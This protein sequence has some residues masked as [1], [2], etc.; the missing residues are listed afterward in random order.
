MSNKI[1][2]KRGN[3]VPTASNLDR[4]ELGFAESNNGLYTK[5]GEDEIVHLNPI[6]DLK[7]FLLNTV[8][9]VGTVYF[10]NDKTFNP[11]TV[12][13]GTWEN[14]SGSYLYLGEENVGET[15]GDINNPINIQDH[16]LTED[17]L[18]SHTHSLEDIN[19]SNESAGTPSGS[20]NLDSHNHYFNETT[21]G[22]SHGHSAYYRADV[23]SGS[24]KLTVLTTSSASGAAG[25][26][27]NGIDSSSGSHSHSFS[28]YTDSASA[29][30]SFD[31]NQLPFHTHTAS[32]SVNYTGQGTGIE[33][34]VEVNLPRFVTLAWK[35][36]A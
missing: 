27:P 15:L 35:R 26:S 24:A 14:V 4:Y 33:H 13:G 2:V 19:I 25:T 8:Y 12:W 29:S 30:G 1:L 5:N 22:G 16:I 36:T 23:G 3:S 32:G 18:A 17:N 7:T 9:P 20:I 28:G 34:E 10:T 31:G 6:A 21:S 11:N